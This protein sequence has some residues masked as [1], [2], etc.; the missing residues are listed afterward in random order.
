MTFPNGEY[1]EIYAY[2]SEYRTYYT[3]TGSFT[4]ET[5]EG[6]WTLISYT[7]T[8]LYVTG[9]NISLGVVEG[10]QATWGDGAGTITWHT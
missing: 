5:T 3:L 4:K 10:Y 7:N 8:T 1:I 6:G 9:P 2:G